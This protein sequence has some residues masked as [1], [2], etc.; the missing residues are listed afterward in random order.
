MKSKEQFEWIDDMQGRISAA[1][2]DSPYVCLFD[3]GLN[4]GHPLLTPIT[5]QADLHA[6]KPAWGVNDRKGHGTSMAGLAAYGDLTKLL[7]GSERVALS[8]RL[9]S[10]KIINDAGPHD[11]ELYGAVTQESAYRVE[12]RCKAK[13][14]LLHGR[15]CR[16]RA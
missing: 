13:T 10:V 4:A 8:H 5:D 7:A 14:C 2:A 1:P 15:H 9:E 11:P 12:S 6:Y 16:R 3:S